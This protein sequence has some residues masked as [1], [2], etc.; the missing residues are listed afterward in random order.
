MVTLRTIKIRV[1]IKS[2]TNF[3]IIVMP[4]VLISSAKLTVF[5]ISNRPSRCFG[6]IS[7]L[8][9][10]SNAWADNCATSGS[11]S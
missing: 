1:P 10:P 4:C 8:A 6:L 2:S 11:G 7:V 3:K 5:K 9:R